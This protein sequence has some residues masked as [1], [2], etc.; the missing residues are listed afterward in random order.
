M[1]VESGGSADEEDETGRGSF[2]GEEG[3][4]EGPLGCGCL[5]VGFGDETGGYGEVG[6]AD[7][8]KGSSV[9]EDEGYEGG[10][11]RRVVRTATFCET[12]AMKK[13]FQ[14]GNVVTIV[15]APGTPCACSCCP[16]LMRG[17][18]DAV[19]AFGLGLMR[20]AVPEAPKPPQPWSAQLMPFWTRMDQSC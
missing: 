11:R 15:A 1:S 13:L 3:R 8:L 5:K 6:T 16:N 17:A 9:F 14:L 7:L 19:V 10:G 2:G 4:Y 18:R 12:N 20:R